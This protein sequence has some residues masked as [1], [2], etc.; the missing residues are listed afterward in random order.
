MFDL[1]ANTPVLQA[2]FDPSLPNSPALEAVLKG[3]HLGKAVVD[4]LRN[5]SQ[6]VLRTDA[7]LTYVGYQTKQRFLE[8]AV[9]HFEHAGPVWLIWPHATTLQPPA[10]EKAKEIQRREFYSVDPHSETLEELRRSLHYECRMRTIDRPLFMR[11][12]WREEMEF[13]AGGVESFLQHGIGL[14]MMRGNEILVEAYASA[15]GIVMAEIG[16]I[17]SEAHRGRGYA[18]I[19][20]AHLIAECERRGVQ[21]YWS[22][23]AD[24]HAS[25]RVA[26]KLGF[27]QG[28]AYQIYAY[29]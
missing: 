22:C 27:Q 2:L 8:D 4:D 25:I 10:I 28:G 20:C 5:P 24:H 11:C 26:Q 13:Y 19:A 6:C 18:A 21:P 3:N 16:V 23:D 17:T 1:P 14:C 12:A 15:V 29:E 7:C 9:M